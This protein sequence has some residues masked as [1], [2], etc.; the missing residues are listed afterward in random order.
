MGQGLDPGELESSWIRFDSEDC[1]GGI[2]PCFYSDGE[3][4]ADIIRIKLL[5]A[6]IRDQMDGNVGVTV[7]QQSVAGAKSKCSDLAKKTSA[8]K[9]ALGVSVAGGAIST[10]AGGVAIAGQAIESKREKDAALAANAAAA[11]AAKAEEATGAAGTDAVPKPGV[12]G[13]ALTSNAAGWATGIGAAAGGAA[14][15]VSASVGL[16]KLAELEKALKECQSA[17]NEIN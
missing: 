14:A 8:L 16:A 5:P 12:V 3:G 1:T 6:T 17:V 9:I 4:W 7:S 2:A 11:E 15:T 10:I 13:S